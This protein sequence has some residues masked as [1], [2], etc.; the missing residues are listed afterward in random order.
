MGYGGGRGHWI[1]GIAPGDD[2]WARYDPPI[3]PASA[4]GVTLLLQVRSLTLDR[5]TNSLLDLL[6]TA[7][8]VNANRVSTRES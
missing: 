2:S 3:C 4:W 5:W 7:G 1:C 6:E 8:N